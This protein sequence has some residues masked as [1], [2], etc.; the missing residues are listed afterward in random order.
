MKAQSSAEVGEA[1]RLHDEATS[2][3]ADA[4]AAAAKAE[5]AMRVL[6]E[7]RKSF[8]TERL[9]TAKGRRELLTQKAAVSRSA[10]ATRQLQLQLVQQMAH[11]TAQ[12]SAIATE[13]PALEP[14]P[15]GAPIPAEAWPKYK[16]SIRPQSMPP[17]RCLLYTSPS[18][19]D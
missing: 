16:P 5:E 19:R 10:E 8:E 3:R 18:P 4:E 1:Q 17:G 6:F 7:Q 11:P 13:A 15:G 14:R 12:G 2:A 9:E